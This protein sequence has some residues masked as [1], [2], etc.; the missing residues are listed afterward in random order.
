MCI[1]AGVISILIPVILIKY[2]NSVVSIIGLVILT[3]VSIVAIL[4]YTLAI[5]G[6]KNLVW[7]LP[8][9]VGFIFLALYFLT[10]RFNKPMNLL[11]MDIV[12]KLGKG[13]LNF[14]FD[15][16]LKRRKDELGRISNALNDLKEQL[17]HVIDDIQDAS[18][19]I[20][21]S[22]NNQSSSAIQVSQGANEQAASIEEILSSVE[23]MLANIQQNAGN[24][25]QTED[26]SIKAVKGI[27]E[28]TQTARISIDAIKEISGKISIINDIAFQTNILA[29]NAAVEAARAGEH[30]KGFAVVA[31]EVRKLAERSKL[32]ANEINLLA[33]KS[34]KL[35]EDAGTLMDRLV[36]EITKTSK[37]VQEITAAS[38]EQNAGANQISNAI[39]QLN[40]VT[41]QNSAASEEMATNAEELTNQAKQLTQ[42]LEF[43][44]N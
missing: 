20:S 29:L 43:F 32:A 39:Q 12:E 44:K 3:L 31:S 7:M 4:A 10:I 35:T 24:A 23:E 37:L 2:K 9:G 16:K 40:Q 22:A 15:A 13:L 14:S 30:G 27:D 36:P 25:K 18:S 34:L 33:N 1:I 5:M 41:Q 21:V 6:F 19:T 8:L 11:T 26:I 17:K 42:M 38:M 28:L